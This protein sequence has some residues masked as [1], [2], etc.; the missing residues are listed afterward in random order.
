MRLPQ[1]LAGVFTASALP[2]SVGYSAE[3]YGPTLAAAEQDAKMTI[4]GDYGPCQDYDY[5]ADGQLAGGTWWAEVSAFCST[6]H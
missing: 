6:Y 1:P 5:Y 2:A 4:L 3:G